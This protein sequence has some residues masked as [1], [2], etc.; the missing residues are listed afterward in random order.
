MLHTGADCLD[1]AGRFLPQGTWQWLRIQ[2]GTEVDIDKIQTASDM[3][4]P[5]FARPRVTYFNVDI[6]HHLRATGP[7]HPDCFYHDYFTSK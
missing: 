1:H 4:Y 7:R 3:P 6:F 2:A 5:H